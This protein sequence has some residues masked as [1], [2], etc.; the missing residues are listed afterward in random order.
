MPR[1]GNSTSVVQSAVSLS[2]VS[3]CAAFAVAVTTFVIGSGEP[4][5][6]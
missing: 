1:S 4:V 5:N 6:V 3:D 2:A